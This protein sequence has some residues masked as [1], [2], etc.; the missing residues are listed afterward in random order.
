MKNQGIGARDRL[1]FI[2]DGG[3]ELVREFDIEDAF[4]IEHRAMSRRL[5]SLDDMKTH[6]RHGQQQWSTGPVQ[7][8]VKEAA[9]RLLGHLDKF[10]N[11][12]LHREQ[13]SEI[14]MLSQLWHWDPDISNLFPGLTS[15]RPKPKPIEIPR[16]LQEFTQKKAALYEEAQAEAEA[17]PHHQ[18]V[19]GIQPPPV[20]LEEID[21]VVDQFVERNPGSSLTE[22]NTNLEAKKNVKEPKK[23]PLVKPE[24]ESKVKIGSM[25]PVPGQ[26]AP[27]LPEEPDHIRRDAWTDA[28]REVTLNDWAFRRETNGHAGVEQRDASVLIWHANE[29]EAR[30][31]LTE[32]TDNHIKVNLRVLLQGRLHQRHEVLTVDHAAKLHL[33]PVRFVTKTLERG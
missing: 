30:L 13:K 17:H 1:E 29:C 14:E 3:S 5:E 23:Y 24:P 6:L 10:L 7:E 12:A 4:D 31:E 11:D 21:E 8:E 20:P 18:P 19:P 2:L 32:M 33:D 27:P 25:V 26:V 16:E 9:G 15:G 22:L 28:L